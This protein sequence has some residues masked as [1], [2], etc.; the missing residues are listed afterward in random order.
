MDAITLHGSLKGLYLTTRRLLK[1]HP[2]HAGG[3]DPV[4]PLKN[5]EV[6]PP[7]PKHQ[8]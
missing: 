8:I 1:C 6:V 4:P 5:S 2:F 3:F 7:S